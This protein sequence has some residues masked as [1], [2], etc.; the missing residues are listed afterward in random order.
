M[1]YSYSSKDDEPPMVPSGDRDLRIVPHKPT[2]ERPDCILD[3]ERIE[4]IKGVE[5]DIREDEE[6]DLPS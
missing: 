1:K 4:R 5:L 6:E 3:I 2:E